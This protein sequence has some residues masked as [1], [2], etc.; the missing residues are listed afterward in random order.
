MVDSTPPLAVA[1]GTESPADLAAFSPPQ[2]RRLEGCDPGTGRLLQQHTIQTEH[3]RKKTWTRRGKL[4]WFVFSARVW[5]IYFMKTI[6]C[7]NSGASTS[8]RAAVPGW[9]FHPEELHSGFCLRHANKL[10]CLISFCCLAMSRT[11]SAET[12]FSVCEV[13][14]R[15]DL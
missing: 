11:G 2:L 9:C 4:V 12:V 14:I 10:A 3:R 1:G 8:V 15:E 5:A 13:N 7:L 6:L